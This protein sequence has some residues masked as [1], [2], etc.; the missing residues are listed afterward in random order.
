[1]SVPVKLLPVEERPREKLLRQ[2]PEALSNAELLAILLRTGVRGCNVIDLAQRLLQHCQK[3]HP[4]NPLAKLLRLREGDLRSAVPG[5]GEAKLCQVLAALQLGVRAKAEPLDFY[6][7][8]NPKAAVEYLVPRMSWREQEQFMVI[9][10]N[11]K[12][13]VISVEDVTE[14]TQTSTLV[15][16]REIFKKAVRQNAHAIILAHNHPS[17]DPTPSREDREIT[18]R[19]KEA[20]RTLGIEVLDHLVIGDRRYVSFR[21]RG[22]VD[23]S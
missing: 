16:P 14:G 22:L 18:L 2:G 21:E 9:L 12:N 20:G 13:H 6:D 3:E 11:A 8:S 17:G 7:V 23:W 5:I 19:L 1:V 4:K 10:L 15:H